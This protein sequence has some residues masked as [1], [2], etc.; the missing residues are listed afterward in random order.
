MTGGAGRRK[1]GPGGGKC[2]AELTVGEGK[3]NIE[4]NDR[5]RQMLD[6]VNSG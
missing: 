1:H 5:Q 2:W 3:Q 4:K 6:G